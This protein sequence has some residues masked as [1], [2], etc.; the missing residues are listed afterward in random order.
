[1]Q[2][3]LCN[4]SGVCGPEE[5]AASEEW[6]YVGEGRGEYRMVDLYKFVGSGAGS[7]DVEAQKRELKRQ[8]AKPGPPQ[9][10]SCFLMLLA[11]AV[12]LLLT[13]IAVLL[14]LR[15]KAASSVQKID[16]TTEFDCGVVSDEWET[17]WSD[18]KIDWCCKHKKN[19]CPSYNCEADAHT[20]EHSWSQRK[21]HWCCENKGLGCPAASDDAI[22]YHDAGGEYDCAE[23]QA[24]MQ[25]AWSS[26]KARWCCDVKQIGCSLV[27]ASSTTVADG[28]TSTSIDDVLAFD[29]SENSVNVHCLSGCWFDGETASCEDRIMYA[30]RKTF[31]GQDDA[32]AQ[33]YRLVQKQCLKSC[34]ACTLEKANCSVPPLHDCDERS[35]AMSEWSYAKRA[36]CCQHHQKG[37][38]STSSQAATTPVHTTSTPVRTTTKATKATKTTKATTTPSTVTMAAPFDCEADLANW[39]AVWTAE[40]KKWC[41]HNENTECPF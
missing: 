13:V 14:I 25:T 39:T 19:T 17:E 41:C 35:K 37:C 24:Q 32:C 1:M 3:G 9:Y 30:A 2:A 8:Y 11:I 21:Q 38:T 28:S 26:S 16:R 15:Q 36:W 7:Y 4:D 40:K 18:T 6:R 20:W 22:V 27:E 5:V 10:C 34:T 29:S 33:A 31:A 23:D 12:A